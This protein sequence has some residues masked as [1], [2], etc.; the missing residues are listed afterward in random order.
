M[1]QK[2]RKALADKE[3]LKTLAYRENLA[4][5]RTRRVHDRV[6]YTTAILWALLAA[7]P[8]LFIG[9]AIPYV[10][11]LTV[12]HDVQSRTEFS[13]HDSIAESVALRNLESGFARRYR[14][15][16]LATWAEEVHGPVDQFLTRA[17]NSDN[18][19]MVRDAAT[20]LGL[21][22]TEDQVNAFWRGAGFAKNDPYHYLVSPM[23]EILDNEIFPQGILPKERF[24][25]ERGRTIQISR[26]DSSHTA[27]VGG[28]RGPLTP[29]QVGPLLERR[30]RVKLSGWIPP[31]LKTAL[32]DVIQ[33]RMRPN[34][35]YDEAVSKTA[36]EERRD[37]LLSR[38]QTVHKNDII[39][40]R[41]SLVTLDKLA[42]L[43]E[44][45]RVFRESQ[46]WRFPATRFVGNFLLFLA[47]AF[48]MVI[49]FKA[50]ESRHLRVIR[51]YLATA[52]L[53][54]FLVF[55]G[56]VLSY[57][58]L[59]GT[60]LPIGL[61][62]GVAALGMNTR[63]AM[64]L[65]SVAS[66]Y[67]LI[68][69]EGRSDLMI[70]HLAAGLFFVNAAPR[71]RYRLSLV[72]VS[73]VAG[74]VG[75]VAFVAWNFARGDL[76]GLLDLTT[77]SQALDD[78]MSSMISA[79]ALVLNWVMCG[80]IILIL[81][82]L[83]EGFFGVT[84]RIHMQD[85]IAQEHPILRR[86][87]IEAPGTYHHCSL[88]STLAEA[89][90]NAIGADGLKARIGGM[91]HDIGKLLK[92]EYFTEN[93]FGV[94]R[95]ESMNPNMSALLIINHVRDGAEMA[96]SFGLPNIVVDMIQQHHGDSM[97]KYFYHKAVTQ[98]PPGAVVAREP[99]LYPGPK[100]QT[101]EAGVLMIADSVEAAVRS[102]DEPS[103]K[104]L[105]NLLDNIVRDRLVEGEFEDSGL[106]M[107]QLAQ[108]KD[109][110]YR[111]LVS[112]YHTRVKYPGQEK[113]AK[114]RKRA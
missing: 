4:H 25:V 29:E 24:E 111:M 93:E 85:L 5:V 17:A 36:Y 7:L 1:A 46:G 38:V 98:A 34:L 90:A 23:T 43:R 32:V 100:P 70:G 31:E 105:R 65:A 75:A 9:R 110:L 27:M 78:S 18:P 62:V 6:Y 52:L 107:R 84:T 39:V 63:T 28:E 101:P 97:M 74:L 33:K 102:L 14:E 8:S 92:P 2:L 26:G 88:V 94:S 13:W 95:H 77:V 104:Y 50:A 48:A 113:E 45:E 19:D 103:P 83:I 15:V 12:S 91:F 57:L 81:L 108:V 55:I 16:P 49:Y 47:V 72:F 76:Q 73:F 44:E 20:T 30:F 54:L 42:M 68:L 56:Y 41:G 69:Y 22:L 89:A 106:S 40:S 61:A 99:F 21:S 58:G 114:G 87:I 64:F 86:L 11:G 112:M 53:G 79:A 37:E 60:M 35:V 51:R 10:V 67:G 109:V 71:C 80:F 96:R 66:L 3:R 82:P 59:P